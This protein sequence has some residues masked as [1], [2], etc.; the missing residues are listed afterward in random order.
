M[1]A[2]KLAKMKLS[3]YLP[4]KGVS[5]RGGGGKIF[6]TMCTSMQLPQKESKIRKTR[7]RKK[8]SFQVIS[9]VTYTKIKA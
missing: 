1:H 8:N 7:E 3:S 5:K 6:V 2:C 4:M 9:S